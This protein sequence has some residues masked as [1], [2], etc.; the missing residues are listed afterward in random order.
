MKN[1][2]PAEAGRLAGENPDYATSD[3]FKAIDG[4]DFPSWSLK[5]QVMTEQEAL[6]YRSN[7]FDVT[8]VWPHKDFPLHPV[9]RMVLN[10]NPDN[11]F[12]EVEQAAF[13]PSHMVPGSPSRAIEL[14]DS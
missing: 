2:T 11:Y 13:S 8:K 1:L 12:A 5:I 9:G 3:L 10:R 7:P 4:G 6:H 14:P